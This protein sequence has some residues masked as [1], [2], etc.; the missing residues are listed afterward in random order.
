M[1]LRFGIAAWILIGL[2]SGPATVVGVWAVAALAAASGFI[3]LPGTAP[4]YAGPQGREADFSEIYVTKEQSG[5]S[6]GLLKQIIAPKSGPPLHVHPG[7]DEFFYVL[8]GT[9]KLQVGDQIKEAAVGSMMFVPRGVAHT[10]QNAGSEP[11]E[12]LVGVMPGGFEGMMVERV[13]MDAEGVKALVKK[14]NMEVVG[15]P[16]PK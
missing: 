9:F 2:L 16:I 14:Y 1:K 6:I 11:G 12:F 13:G 7:E 3:V 8:K 10:F 4:R 5:G 15:P